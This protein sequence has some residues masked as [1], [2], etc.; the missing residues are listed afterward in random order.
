MPPK[1]HRSTKEGLIILVGLAIIGIG[2]LHSQF[3]ILDYAKAELMSLLNAVLPATSVVSTNNAMAP[4]AALPADSAA[5]DTLALRIVQTQHE[6]DSGYIAAH[7]ARQVQG[8][9]K[10]FT[11]NF[12]GQ[13]VPKTAGLPDNTDSL[14]LKIE[15]EA[16]LTPED[17]QQIDD[18]NKTRSHLGGQNVAEEF[19]RALQQSKKARTTAQKLNLWKS[20]L[21]GAPDTEYQVFAK[22][23]L[24]L[25]L[26][27]AADSS[28]ESLQLAEA[29]DFFEQNTNQ[30]RPLMGHSRFEQELAVL[31]RE[32]RNAR[33]RR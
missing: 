21:Q 22:Y 23:H 26:A 16:R 28:Q 1:S 4:G 14:R 19:F 2:V 18:F 7:K 31:R 13:Q 20:Y 5:V 32:L 6:S 27:A 25:A 30:L 15:N 12:V 17:L 8:V 10:A 9:P 24:A 3:G 11:S 29:V 33:L